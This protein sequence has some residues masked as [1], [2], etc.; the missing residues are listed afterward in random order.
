MDQEVAI[1][2]LEY[3]H[4]VLE[5]N[6]FLLPEALE[7]LSC[8]PADRRLPRRNTRPCDPDLA[9][10]SLFNVEDKTQV[11]ADVVG[12]V[13]Q[14]ARAP[15]LDIRARTDPQAAVARAQKRKDSGRTN[16]LAG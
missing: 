14:T 12:I 8:H 3:V 2:V 7:F 9:V 6:A 5:R 1:W 4:Y 11:V 15:T 16:R 13:G 10:M